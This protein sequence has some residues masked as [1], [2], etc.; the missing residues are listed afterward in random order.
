MAEIEEVCARLCLLTRE[1]WQKGLPAPM[2]REMV[3]RMLQK[4][5]LSA[6]T[7]RQVQGVSEE[8]YLRAE[9]LLSR[10]A[11]MYQ[12]V[13]RT[14]AQ[15]YD[16][17]LP[18]D[19]DWPINLYALGEQM[20][21]FLFV[22]GNR[23]LFRRRCVAVAGSRAIEPSTKLLARK[24][25][26]Q[27]AREGYVMVSGG[28]NGV[29]TEAH[30][31]L[32]EKGGSL[33]LVPA[34]P[35]QRLLGQEEL[36]HALKENRLFIVCDT[37]PEERFSAPKALMRNHTIYALGDAAIAVASRKKRG[38]TWDGAMACLR[39]RYTP[40]YVADEIGPDFIGNLHL[41][42]QGANLVC[43]RRSLGDQLFTKEKWICR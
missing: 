22:R 12:A 30:C 7:L 16:V 35:V 2:P 5:A 43:L 10:A 34:M 33:I 40:V 17:L 25:G 36:R 14:L 11:Q 19:E 13:E 9:A 20:P 28:A 8:C 38:G 1:A 37:W 4:G 21:Q 23:E 27:L 18:E 32:F 24:C 6:L 29:D 39:G 15:G 31:G 3:R 42:S 26:A 41:L